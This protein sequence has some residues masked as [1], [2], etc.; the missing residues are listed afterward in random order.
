MQTIKSLHAPFVG[1]RGP[2][3]RLKAA[4]A[5]A[6]GPRPETALR[7]AQTTPRMYAADLDLDCP[8]VLIGLRGADFDQA[9]VWL[10]AQGAAVR[11]LP[12]SLLEAPGR[13]AALRPSHLFVDLEAIGGIEDT[14]DTLRAFRDDFA[15]IPLILVS[16]GFLTN[17]FSTE[18]LALCDVSLRAPV[19]FAALEFAMAQAEVNNL[20]WQDRLNDLRGQAPQ[21]SGNLLRGHSHAAV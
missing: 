18:R 16:S 10:D 1:P 14:Y 19:T 4:V 20:C 9:R 17:D 12:A 13:I 3:A 11:S 21:D 5:D 15:D 7:G 8:V 6:F 2:V